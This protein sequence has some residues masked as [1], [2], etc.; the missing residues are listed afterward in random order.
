VPWPLLSLVGGVILAALAIALR[1]FSL[2]GGALEVLLLLLALLPI[3]A[4]LVGLVLYSKKESRQVEE[5]HHEPRIYV[6][7]PCAIDRSLLD[8][9]ARAEQTLKQ[10]LEERQWEIDLP[11]YE[12][13]HQLAE[14]RRQEGDL[15]G[16]FREYC[17]AM[18]PLN[19][20]L[21]KYR[22]KEEMFQPVWDKA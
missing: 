1:V 19:V 13:H 18:R 20:A 11:A 17:R 5:E 4:G 10:R 15:A 6:Q 22:S 16:A 12:E 9:V 2:A 3:G 21:Q 8:K 7:K 14:R